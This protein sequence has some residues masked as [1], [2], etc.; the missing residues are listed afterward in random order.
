MKILR[1][2]AENFRNITFAEVEL[3]GMRHFLLGP[4]GQ[5]KTNLL[6]A[7]G[8]LNA[9]RS[10]RTRDVSLLVKHGARTARVWF[11]I[12]HDSEGR[13]TVEF[14]LGANTK[15]VLVNGAPV[16]RLEDFMGRFPTAVFCSDDIA[17]L[18]G[19]PSDRRRWL[20]QNLASTSREYFVALRRYH[21][22][23]EARNRLLKDAE[24]RE[25]HYTPFERVMADAA[26]PLVA[27]RTG[28]CAALASGLVAAC[29]AIGQS[30]ESPALEYRPSSGACA[31]AESWMARW[32]RDRADDQ[33]LR[34]TRCGPHRDDFLFKLFGRAAIDVASEGQQRALVLGLSL[35]ELARRR[36]CSPTAPVVLA[37]D[38]VGEL[39]PARRAAFKRALGDDLQVLATGT[40]APEFSD[41]WRIHAV[42]AGEYR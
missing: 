6:E 22:A 38:I 41:P 17:L 31:D 15:S 33:R 10:F 25:S 13:V 9:V 28:A 24:T 4:N 11:D 37:D 5:G 12:G 7:A 16:N 18:R 23:L 29:A 3:G 30:E 32:A 40:T 36:A 35:A 42:Y 19:S 26:V 14:Q 27:A 21:G 1:I 39:D 8:L 20:D 2:R 34:A